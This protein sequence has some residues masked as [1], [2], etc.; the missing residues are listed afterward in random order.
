MRANFSSLSLIGF[1][2]FIE[3]SYFLELT[4]E[5]P[6]TQ[7]TQRT[8]G[9]R[10]SSVDTDPGQANIKPKS[11]GPEGGINFTNYGLRL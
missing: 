8:K 1:I 5:T 4:Q 6:R 10:T 3:L 7:G 9:G 2:E 11:T